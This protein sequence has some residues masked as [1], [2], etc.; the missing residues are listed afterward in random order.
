MKKLG[1]ILLLVV[2]ISTTNLN[3]QYSEFKVSVTGEGTPVLLIPG[4]TCTEKVWEETV[5]AIAK[6]YECH[7]FTL[8]GFGG[9]PPIEFPWLPKI[10]DAILNY[11]KAK[12]LTD[13]VVVGHSLGGTLAMWLA[14]ED[15]ALFKKLIVV[16]AL[17]STGALM[18]PDFKPENMVYDNPYSNRLLAMDS[19]SFKAMAKQMASYMAINKTVHAQ[20]TDWILESDRKTYV[21]GYTDLLKLD[22]RE[23]I[24]QISIP[25]T[26]LAATH[27]NK[28]VMKAQYE[29]QYVKLP[30]KKIVYAED[31]G[32]F[33]MY[34]KPEW[35]ISTLISELEQSE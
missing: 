5:A 33:I 2:Y 15:E 16:D 31:A 8:A 21:Y 32:H 4:F 20:L 35:F 28:E 12:K 1:F 11:V 29:K 23:T 19:L 24:A 7:S 25:V 9:V 17:P 26:V 30:H 6:D 34:D 10:K 27:P 13:V 3:A 18:V 22:L 14:T